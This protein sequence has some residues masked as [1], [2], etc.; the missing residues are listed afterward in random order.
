[1]NT[2]GNSENGS[3]EASGQSPTLTNARHR[4]TSSVNAFRPQALMRLPDTSYGRM[5][6]PILCIPAIW[7]DRFPS[8]KPVDEY[9]DIT[10]PAFHKVIKKTLARLDRYV[11]FRDYLEPCSQR[12]RTSLYSYRLAH[13]DSWTDFGAP[14]GRGSSRISQTLF[15]LSSSFGLM[16][17]P[18]LEPNAGITV[19]FPSSP[20]LFSL[21]QLYLEPVLDT[22]RHHE[23]L[24]VLLAQRRQAK[25]E[26][27][28]RGHNTIAVALGIDVFRRV[29]DFS[30][31]RS[32]I[33]ST[34]IFAMEAP[35]LRFKNRWNSG[36]AS[37]FKISEIESLVYAPYQWH[38]SKCW[39][40]RIYEMISIARYLHIP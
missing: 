16:I 19:I 3:S 36:S 4:F 31:P 11:S 8:F 34:T 29:L 28:R 9:R 37:L 24:N 18:S 13:A 1:M 39:T 6:G 15:R 40:P 21:S 17:A 33:L 23:P 25:D 32:G 22:T 7:P 26:N 5:M 2:S 38:H 14:S 12:L 10:C 30:I 35:P 20:S 27:L